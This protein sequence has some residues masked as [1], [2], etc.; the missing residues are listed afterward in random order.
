MLTCRTSITNSSSF[1]KTSKSDARTRLDEWR[2]R[3]VPGDCVAGLR[4]LPD[5]CADLIIADPPYNLAKN[6]GA[7]NEKDRKKE[8]LPW[9]REW[10]THCERVLKPGGSIFVY[11]IHHH[12][13]WI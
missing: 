3:I 1:S 11:G 9:C 4:A 12:L 10:L 13:C 8:W 7:W 2:G 6:F 5:E